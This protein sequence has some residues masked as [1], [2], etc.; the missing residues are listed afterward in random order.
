MNYKLHFT[1]VFGINKPEEELD[2]FDVNLKFDSPLFI[3]PFLIKNSPRKEDRFLFERYRTFIKKALEEMKRYDFSNKKHKEMFLDFITFKEPKQL[4]LGY[5]IDSNEGNGPSGQFAESL[6]NFFINN[7][8]RKLL[9]DDSL[10]P[11]NKINPAIF[12]LVAEKMGPDGI[13]DM[14]AGLFLDYFIEYTQ[15]ICNENSIE[16][17]ELPIT[18]YFDFKKEEW[19]NGSYVKL[20]KNPFTG[21]AI[22]LVPKRFLRSSDIVRDA[23]ITQRVKNILSLDSALSIKFASFIEKNI[24]EIDKGEVVSVLFENLEMIKVVLKGMESDSPGEYDFVTDPYNLLA[25]KKFYDIFNNDQD[26][27]SYEELFN[28]LKKFIND[29]Q[30]YIK[31]NGGW[32]H[33]W[34]KNNREGYARCKEDA[35]GRLFHAMGYSWYKKNI[36]ITFMNETSNGNGFVDFY[37][38]YK[39]CRIVIEVKLLS[40]NSITGEEKIPAYIHGVVSQLPEYAKQH[41]AMYAIYITGQ[42][43]KSKEKDHSSRKEEIQN[44]CDNVENSL[45]EEISNFKKLE[46]FNI[47]LS[48]QPTPSKK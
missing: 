46:Y 28:D 43:Y 42:H 35:F 37:I 11:D 3:D 22:L 15:D 41:N 5:T 12:S 40:N 34:N 26:I 39:R 32:K 13:S 20:P 48:I 29:F 25:I 16:L 9:E 7:S 44:V 19:I 23:N 31:H 2:F 1:Q 47:D 4:Y 30:N 45:L 27:T 33:L 14:S 36:N 38:V 21:E 17:F 10:Y 8:L 18:R 24:S 6:F